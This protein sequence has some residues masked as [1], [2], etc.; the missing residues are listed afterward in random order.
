VTEL[1]NNSVPLGQHAIFSKLIRGGGWA[2]FGKMLTY[3]LGLVVTLILAKLLTAAEMGAY[4]LVIS[5]VMLSSTLVRAGLDVTMCKVIALSLANNRPRAV[6]KTIHIGVVALTITGLVA[7]LLFMNEPGIWLFGRLHGGEQLYDTLGFVAV[8]VIAFAGVGFSCEILRGFSDLRSAALLDQQLMQRI[9]LLIALLVWFFFEFTIDLHGVLLMTTTA[10]ILSASLGATMVA[11]KFSS[12]GDYG[13]TIHTSDV[14]RQAPPFL[15]LRINNWVLDGAAIWVLSLSRPLEEAALYGA[16]NIVALL[17][18][19][20]LQV[21]NSAV[22]PTVVTLHAH[23]QTGE[24]TTV[25][26]A[27][28]AIAAAPAIF[29]GC[30]LYLYGEVALTLL[31]TEEYK[32][33]YL[34]LILL[35]AGRVISTFFGLP[36]IL[37]SMTNHQVAVFRVLS[38]ASALTLIGYLF[39][40]SSYGPVGVATVGATSVVL[41]GLLLSLIAYRLLGVNTLPQFSIRSWKLLLKR[42]SNR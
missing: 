19:A 31:F 7:V 30:A 13:N 39:A 6:R 22:S 42:N 1:A 38:V 8:M 32:S 41:Q 5:T 25:L 36:A 20:P 9:L 12:L 21:V 33:A 3:P 10:M 18:L 29:M 37:L 23:G 11:R 27:A 24:L 26:R 15:L 4:F 35:T 34:I 17:L 40:A 14:L 16:A 2:F 28:A